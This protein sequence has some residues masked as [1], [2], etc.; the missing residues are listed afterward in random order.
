MA[1]KPRSPAG[2]GNPLTKTA[3]DAEYARFTRFMSHYLC[4]L[5]VLS[6]FDYAS[7][8]P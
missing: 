1:R 3:E 2:N 7:L 4:V 5:G 6:G 8:A